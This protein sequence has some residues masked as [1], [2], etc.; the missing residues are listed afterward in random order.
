MHRKLLASYNELNRHFYESLGADFSDTRNF[1]WQG[2]NQLLPFFKLAASKPLHI[3]DLGCGN[4]RLL[5]FL[6]VHLSQSFDYLG[7]DSSKQLLSLA[8]AK[9]SQQDFQHFDLLEKYLA[10]GKI[11]LPTSKKF[12]LIVLFGLTHHLSSSA[13]RRQLLFDLRKSLSDGGF[14]IVSNWQFARERERFDKNILTGQKVWQ[15]RQLSWLAKIKLTFLLLGLEKN[16]YLLDWRQGQQAGQV[17]RY[18]HFLAE[19]EML[20]LTAASGWRIATSFFAD[21]KSS[22]L[23]QYFV[24][25]AL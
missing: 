15:S 7:L 1:S 3:L 16:D 13:L 12:D 17:F 18:C 4:G 24:L 23:N 8:R 14:L 9:Y 21:G 25:Q 19:E 2:W 10:I 22:K 6:Q 5:E 20:E 11:I